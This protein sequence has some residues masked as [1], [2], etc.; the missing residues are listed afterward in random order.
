M[1]SVFNRFK[2]RK[3]SY[4]FKMN[5]IDINTGVINSNSKKKINKNSSL[6]NFSELKKEMLFKENINNENL[7]IN[8]NDYINP[9]VSNKTKRNILNLY[10][11]I[12]NN[13]NKYN[14]TKIKNKNSEINEKKTKAIKQFL[15]SNKIK[16]EKENK[17][18]S[19][20]FKKLKE[21]FQFDWNNKT[22]S[23]NFFSKAKN[24]KK[25]KHRNM[26]SQNLYPD[27]Y[28]SK[29]RFDDILK[30]QIENIRDKSK[31]TKENMS[32]KNIINCT[33]RLEK[34]ISRNKSEPIFESLSQ[35]HIHIM[36]SIK[37]DNDNEE[38]NNFKN[39]FL[40]KK[41]FL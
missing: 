8:L 38:L 36:N 32:V 34:I 41:Y 3:N 7:N 25:I 17:N 37:K 6:E 15:I 14:N 40:P 9:K 31:N 12:N 5:T 24:A 23:K 21:E 16:N 19:Y 11:K 22:Y 39:S 29:N 4:F 2:N 33:Q 26:I 35:R 18:N 20:I 13:Q 28:T 27:Y 30:E 10:S 1:A